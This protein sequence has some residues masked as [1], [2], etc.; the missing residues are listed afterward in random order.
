[1]YFW[2]T[3]NK[4][5]IQLIWGILNIVTFFAIVI[6]CMKKAVE[7]RQKIGLFAAIIFSFFALSFISKPSNSSDYKKFEFKK[8]NPNQDT[9][10]S[11]VILEE[12]LTTKIE[13]GVIRDE[14]NAI[15][16]IVTRNG[17]VSG[18]EWQTQSIIV[19]KLEP[20]DTYQYIVNGT[21]KW[22]I[23]GIDIYSEFKEF[24]GVKELKPR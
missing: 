24:R 15:S 7:I 17:F 3:E 16:A 21:R 8:R 19:N 11:K 13:L 22:K 23:I 14:E 1:M 20:K 5:M 9:F 18:T 12:D 2:Y 4:F 6:F 10:F